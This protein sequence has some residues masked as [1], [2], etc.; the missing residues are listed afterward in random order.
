[1]NVRIDKLVGNQGERDQWRPSRVYASGQAASKVRYSSRGR[2]AAGPDMG[3]ELIT[4]GHS[5]QYL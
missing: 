3:E 5:G 4:A 2:L 1:M